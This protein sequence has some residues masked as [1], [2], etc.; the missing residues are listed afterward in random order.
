MKIRSFLAFSILL[1][2]SAVF[3]QLSED[4]VRELIK[5]ASEKDLVAMNSNFLMD[6]YFYRADLVAD[7]LLELNSESSNYNYRKGYST[8]L[9]SEDFAE[10]LPHLEKAVKHVHKKF[11]MFSTNDN[12][13]PY[14]AYFYMGQCYHQNENI[15]K[16]EEYFNKFLKYSNKESDLVPRAQ[17]HLIQCAEA[18]VQM[19]NPVNVFLKN[20]GPAINTQYPEYSPVVS[21]DGSALYFTSRRPWYKKISE[22]FKDPLLNMYT[23]D[24]YVS[25]QDFDQEWSEPIRLDFC[26]P[27]R[28]EATSAVS[29]DERKIYLYLDSTGGGDI[30]YADFY[31]ARFSDIQFLTID[32]VNTE[33]WETHCMMSNDLKRIYFVS[34]RPGG[35][36]GRDIYYCENLGENKWSGPINM[37]PNINSPYDEDAPFIS[38]DNKTLHYSTNGEKS[39]GGF[40]IMRSELQADKTWSEGKNLGYPFNST[41]DDIFYT[42]TIDGL[43]GYM[44]SYRKNGNG[45]KDIYEIY[46]ES[47]GRQNISVLKG[48]FTSEDGKPLED[49]LV[50]MVNVK[51]LDCDVDLDRV[52]YPRPRDGFFITGLEPCKNYQINYQ[53][54]TD[55]LTLKTDSFKTSCDSIHLTVTRNLVLNMAR[56][57]L[58][59]NFEDLTLKEFFDFNKTKLS[60]EEGDLHDFLETINSQLTAGRKKITI[61]VYSS[62]SKV[63]TKTFKTNDLLTVKRAEDAVNNMQAY[64]DAK[65]E[66]KDRVNIVVVTTLVQGPEYAGDPSNVEKY[67]PFQYI[68]LTTE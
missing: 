38:A 63:P 68:N 39:I 30:Y 29:S 34:N 36:G 60:T 2:N 14:D 40:D 3:A 57:A 18:R 67:R 42:T 59:D 28:N 56:N 55:S 22:E 12:G 62:A 37:G 52:I 53:N 5:T 7:K 61:N 13:C 45:D 54:I 8:I 48:F 4:E 65:P 20:I 27:N 15:D 35:F 24:I 19:K 17:L 33:Y 50:V 47:F 31:S 51:C 58:V 43:K 41:S 25:Y 46:N 32:G 49:N 64:F 21:L 44:T 16:A 11:D 1:L 23:E 26:E 66:I 9:L 6:G 10:A